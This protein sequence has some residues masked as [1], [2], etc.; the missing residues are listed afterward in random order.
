MAQNNCQRNILLS[1][2][3]K[4]ASKAHVAT[5]C[6]MSETSMAM[7]RQYASGRR[8]PSAGKAAAIADAMSWAYAFNPDEMPA[9]SRADLCD[10]C[11]DCPHFNK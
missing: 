4:A 9:L 8:F 7:M 5:V 11:K 2:W 10:A 6:H 1:E 3:L